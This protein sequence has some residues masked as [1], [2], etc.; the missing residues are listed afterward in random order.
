VV[1]RTYE[2]GDF[3]NDLPETCANCTASDN[4]FNLLSEVGAREAQSS[5]R[6]ALT[7]WP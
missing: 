7:T 4:A 2:F 5:I 6:Q 1:A 3:V